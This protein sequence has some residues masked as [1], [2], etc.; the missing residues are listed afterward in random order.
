MLMTLIRSLI[1]LFSS[2]QG[3]KQTPLHSSFDVVSLATGHPSSGIRVKY[4]LFHRL[5]VTGLHT[6]APAKTKGPA[7]YLL[8]SKFVLMNNYYFD[9]AS[10]V[11]VCILDHYSMM[12]SDFF[13]VISNIN[14]SIAK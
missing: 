13:L 12:K 10:K 14:H 11:T 8:T 9:I 7:Q 6:L 2:K 1:C 5:K 3:T 4:M